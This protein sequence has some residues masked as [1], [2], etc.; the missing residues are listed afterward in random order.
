MKK[1][2]SLARTRSKTRGKR[3]KMLVKLEKTTTFWRVERV[4]KYAPLVACVFVRFFVKQYANDELK[5]NAKHLIV[6]LYMNSNK[7]HS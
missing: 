4:H 5:F 1:E 6:S 2:L 7:F 3:R